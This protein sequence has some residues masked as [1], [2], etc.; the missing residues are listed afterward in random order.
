MMENPD[1]TVHCV[2]SDGRELVRYNRG[3]KWW[4]EGQGRMSIH[5]RDAVAL[6]IQ[7]GQQFY[8]GRPG[9]GSFDRK[10]K[11]YVS[12]RKGA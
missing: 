9:G 8:F 7:R 10:V 1:R 3:G 4:V 2:L 6:A 11:P 5:M 12:G